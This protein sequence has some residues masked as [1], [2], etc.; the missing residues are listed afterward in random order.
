MD[1]IKHCAETLRRAGYVVAQHKFSAPYLMKYGFQAKTIVDVGVNAGSAPLYRA[2][3][4]RQFVLVEPLPHSEQK[5]RKVYPWLN[6][7]DFFACAAGSERGEIEFITRRGK[8]W[9]SGPFARADD[10]EAEKTLVQVERLDD[11]LSRRAHEKPFGVKIDVEGFELPVID[12][13]G[14]LTSEVEFF[15]IETSL[16]RVFQKDDRFSDLVAKMKG[17]G[18][19]LADILNILGHQPAGLDCLFLPSDDSRFT[20]K[21]ASPSSGRSDMPKR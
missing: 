13:L 6:I 3:R 21:E 7:V 2:F 8:P 12:G 5:V 15:I 11:L 17:I 10:G 9:F 20:L 1:E 14:A 16:K 18:F 4:D 19:E